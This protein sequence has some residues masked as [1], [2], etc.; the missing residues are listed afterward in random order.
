MKRLLHVE[1]SK[2]RPSLE[3]IFNEVVAVHSFP[4]NSNK[5]RAG[6]DLPRVYRRLGNYCSHIR[7]CISQSFDRISKSKHI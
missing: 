1:L 7:T 4:G 2:S 5:Q 6:N 3:C